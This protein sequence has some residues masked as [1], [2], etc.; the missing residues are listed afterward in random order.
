[1]SKKHKILC[2][3]DEQDIVDALFRLF[4]K[5][6][7]VLTATSGSDGLHLLND[8]K[9]S[10]IISDQ[11]MPGMN[12]VE[13]LKKSIEIDPNCMRIL[14][15]GY[16]DIESVIESINSGE[17]YRYITK[18]WD[19]IDL[20]NTVNKSIEKYE[21]R[22][23]LQQKN[24]ELSKANKELKILDQSKTQFMYLINHE[25]KTPLTV[26]TS[27]TDLL[28]ET[29]IDEEQ[30]KFINRIQKS[31]DK[32]QNIVNDVLDLI[33]AETG[34]LEV[35]K[36]T[37]STNDITSNISKLFETHLDKKSLKLD[38]KD[39]NLS[40]NSDK[41]IIHSVLT[42]ILDN[43]IKF[44]HNQSKVILEVKENENSA[45]FV[46]INK[47]DEVQPE[48]IENIFK[49][50]TLDENM[51]NHTTGIGLGLSL[52]QAYLKC[53]SSTLQITCDKGEFKASFI[54]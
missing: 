15:T 27:Y 54:I 29:K 32:L 38:I 47:G 34:I 16:T 5:D 3:D 26:I 14:L 13:T 9:V 35:N 39:S 6:Y 44:S 42:K 2:I 24:L 20:V 31:N 33:K 28:K 11:K 51:L 19:P 22:S 12:G 43:A 30:N 49:P 7:D 36:M 18:P 37:I 25:L 53:L 10:L 1:M 50:F 45:E 52:S 40:I 4:R 8:N 23:E 41:K 21:I 17:V 48:V 46:V